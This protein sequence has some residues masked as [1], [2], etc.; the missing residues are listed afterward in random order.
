MRISDWSSDVCSS[1]LIR[2]EVFGNLYLTSRKRGQF[3]EED[4]QLLEALASTAGF[5][6]QNARLFQESQLR[7]R[8]MSATAQLSSALLSTPL[9]QALDLIAGRV[10]NVS[11]AG[12][13][14]IQVPTDDGAE[15]RGAAM[16]RDAEQTRHRKSVV[17]GKR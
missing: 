5:A 12:R 9:D 3:S 14:P 11:G 16:R 6:I 17:Q 10:L 4:E 13:V 7:E 15:L 1:D 8:W 2:G